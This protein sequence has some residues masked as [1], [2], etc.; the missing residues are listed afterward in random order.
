MVIQCPSCTT[1]YRLNLESLP[2]RKTFVKC[3]NCG[4]PIYIDPPADAAPDAGPARPETPPSPPASP[5]ARDPAEVAC[6]QC[7]TRY[8]LP[9]E[10]LARPRVKLKCTHCGNVFAPPSPSESAGKFREPAEPASR[11]R[12]FFPG[13]AGEPEREETSGERPMPVPDEQ[14]LEGM[15]DDLRERTTPFAAPPAGAG[16]PADLPK[17]APAPPPPSPAPKQEAATEAFLESDLDTLG[18]RAAQDTRPRR[19]VA[20]AFNPEQAYLEAVS[21]DDDTITEAPRPVRGTV[22]DSQKYQF[23]L[24]PGPLSEAETGVPDAAPPGRDALPAGHRPPGASGVRPAPVMPLKPTPPA[25][26]IPESAEL[27][28]EIAP[29]PDVA[30]AGPD[31][32]AD[33]LD[34]DAVASGLDLEP[35]AEDVDAL[36]Q[37]HGIEEPPLPDLPRLAPQTMRPGTL[38]MAGMGTR[39]LRGWGEQA[40]AIGAIVLAVGMLALLFWLGFRLA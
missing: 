17:P 31:L 39:L 6:T 15:F 8:R 40:L 21:L 27:G 25:V 19:P 3:R 2:N 28:V 24:K 26:S 11:P 29:P 37:I 35:A 5:P 33:S 36:L 4:T 30:A 32:A 9:A 38:G 10:A 34:L 22:P 23:F 13:A 7:G 14:Q 18:D 1:K 20:S 12:E 16:S